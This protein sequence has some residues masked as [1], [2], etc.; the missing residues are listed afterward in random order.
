MTTHQVNVTL[1]GVKSPEGIARI[2]D[3]MDARDRVDFEC[4]ADQEIK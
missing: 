1:P 3:A 2:N 4:G